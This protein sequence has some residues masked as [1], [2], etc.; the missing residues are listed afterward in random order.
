MG[1]V[2]R[3]AWDSFDYW[4]GAAA[5]VAVTAFAPIHHPW[6]LIGFCLAWGFGEVIWKSYRRPA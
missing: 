1:R 4:F 5:G 3:S 6:A 2:N